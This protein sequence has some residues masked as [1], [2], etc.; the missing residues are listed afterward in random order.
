MN[1]ALGT[2]QL[3]F[4][5]GISNTKG[6]TKK[7]EAKQI[8]TLAQQYNINTIDTAS[9]YGK[10]E[11]VIGEF[12]Q[13]N[14]FNYQI[15][16]KLSLQ[17]CLQSS[18]QNVLTS[19][20]ARLQTKSV[21]G[22]MIHDS[23]KLLAC[24]AK[25]I[26]DIVRQ[27]K[28]LKHKG[29]CK[30]IGVSVYSPEQLKQVLTLIDIDIVQFPLNIFDQRFLNNDLLIN[31]R[32]N[33]IEVHARSLFLQG[34]LL[35]D[36]HD[37]PDYFNQYD[38]AFSKLSLFCKLHS[39]STLEACLAFAK[40]QPQIDKF[41]IGI[42]SSAELTQIVNLYKAVPTISPNQFSDLARNELALINPALWVTDH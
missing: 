25:E 13:S 18:V 9:G 32:K 7:S 19:S 42:S 39:L 17:A 37:K 15:V 2:A 29:L 6:Q 40:A 38:E 34:L 4:D 20:L 14:L 21:Y 22:V 8:L 35:M 12:S 10:S 1:I 28:Q 24:S 16:T 27:F 23:D 26:L 31:L 36:K 3:G 33:N 11:N 30:R 5:Y 41:V